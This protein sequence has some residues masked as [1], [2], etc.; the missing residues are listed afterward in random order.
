MSDASNIPIDQYR[1]TLAESVHFSNKTINSNIE[2]GGIRLAKSQA[3][4]LNSISV[5]EHYWL[6]ILPFPPITKPMQ[7]RPLRF[8]KPSN[9]RC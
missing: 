9:Q 1:Q 8:L 4:D 5:R 2:K 7:V 3:L 6:T